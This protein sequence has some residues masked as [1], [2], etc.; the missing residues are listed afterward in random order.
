[1]KLKKEV[2]K[3]DEERRGEGWRG[4]GRKKVKEMKGGR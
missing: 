3:E 1:M 2:H 4:R